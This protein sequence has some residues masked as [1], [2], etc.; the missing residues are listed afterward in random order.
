MKRI[1]PFVTG[2]VVVP[3]MLG[4]CTWLA[5]VFGGTP[6]ATTKTTIV[7]TFTDGCNAYAAALSIAADALTANL[8]SATQIS[9]VQQ[10]KA[11]ADPICTGPQPTNLAS[12]FVTVATATLSL[13]KVN[14]GGQ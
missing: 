11:L 14:A 1:N 8:L 13:G 2:I 7:E 9:E 4:G 5:G 3:L 12:A 6:D 10:A